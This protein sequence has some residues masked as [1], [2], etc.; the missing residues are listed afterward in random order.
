MLAPGAVGSADSPDRVHSL[1]IPEL[2]QI[3]A[4]DFILG[5]S[6]DEREVAYQLDEVAYGN[7]VTRQQR[8]YAAEHARTRKYTNAY[9]ITRTPITNFQYAA[10]IS[11]TGRAAPDVERS[12]WASYG[13]V[14]PYERTRRFAWVDGRP[15]ASRERHPVV[16]VSQLDARAY[17]AW[18]SDIT[19]YTWRLP[20]EEEWE[21][22]ARGTDGRHFPWGNTF[23]PTLVNSLDRGPFDTQPV[24][25]YPNG[26]SPYG[27]QDA[28]GQVYEWTSTT[29]G[30]DRAIVKGGSWDDRGCGVCRPAARHSRPI[31]LK[32]IL[33]GFRLVRV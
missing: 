27:M 5:S 20:I 16:L 21:K 17:A 25:S 12:T 24:G 26:A 3:P 4:G 1:P 2:V 7:N 6:P 15:S 22:A 14:H 8:W 10:F 31:T 29:S 30:K 33:I 23:D 11:T 28:A 19:G 18:L 13:L 9:A 32:H